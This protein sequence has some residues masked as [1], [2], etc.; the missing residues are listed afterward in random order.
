MF[1]MGTARKVGGFW[2]WSPGIAAILTKFIFREKLQ[3][4]GWQL[5]ERKYLILGLAIPFLYASMIYS[6]VWVTGLGRFTPQPIIKMLI[7]VTVGLVVAC[8]TAL[9]EEI[10]WRGFL[11]PE[12]NKIMPF[13]N[14]AL[15]TGLVW[16]VWHYPAIIFAD[17]NSETPIFIQLGL[18]TVA[19]IGFSIFSAWL[20]IKSGSIWP[21]VLWHGGHNLFIQQI[22]L[23]MTSN[24]GITDYFVDD[25]G[26]GVFLAASIL[27]IVYWRKR[28]ELLNKG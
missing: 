26:V 28:V 4:I 11:V 24:T 22:F 27:G 20:R 18:I 9:G 19:V 14:V 15:M 25:F 17:Y 13:T 16:A 12:L 23:S 1:S 3:D 5:G 6:L 21:A 8:V 2:M 10:G 7:F